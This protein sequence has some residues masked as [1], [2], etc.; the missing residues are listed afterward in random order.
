MERSGPQPPIQPLS[1][2]TWRSIE[3]RVFEEL[4]R[5]VP[6]S[7]PTLPQRAPFGLAALGL[8]ALALA[9]AVLLSRSTVPDIPSSAANGA[10][11]PSGASRAVSPPA[12]VEPAPSEVAIPTRVSSGVV[13]TRQPI[14]D[15][16]LTLAEHTEIEI[17]GSE[18]KGWRVRL[19]RGEV[20]CEIAPRLGRPAFVVAAADV[21][22]KVIGTRFDVIQASDA[23]RVR[24]QEGH[25]QVLHAGLVTLLGPGESWPGATQHA[26]PPPPSRRARSTQPPDRAQQEFERAARLEASDPERALALYAR[27]SRAR[28]EWA[29]N[30]LY[31]RARLLFERGDQPRARALSARYLEKYPNGTNAAD[32]RRLLASDGSR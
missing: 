29:A 10:R 30:A 19:E 17:A 3:A 22:V 11:A 28:N 25:V 15:S 18:A 27:I 20:H 6:R 12:P 14:G 23:T 26:L 13:P 21:E 2:S 32:A 31:A 16:L 4:E 24:V 7:R 1:E 9:A 5:P 8:A